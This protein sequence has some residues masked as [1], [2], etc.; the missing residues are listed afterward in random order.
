MDGGSGGRRARVTTI[1]PSLASTWKPAGCRTPRNCSIWASVQP[2]RGERQLARL[3]AQVLDRR[4]LVRPGRGRGLQH[5]LEVAVGG[6]AGVRAQ[7]LGLAQHDGAGVALDVGIGDPRIALLHQRL[8]RVAARPATSFFWCQAQRLRPTICATASAADADP[9]RPPGRAHRLAQ[10]VASGARAAGLA[11]RG[12]T[13]AGSRGCG[14]PAAG[15]AR[16]ASRSPARPATARRRR[17]RRARRSSGSSPAAGCGTRARARPPSRRTVATPSTCAQVSTVPPR[18]RGIGRGG[19]VE[20]AHR[21]LV[22][23]GHGHDP[24][25]E[26]AALLQRLELLLQPGAVDGGDPGLLAGRPPAARP[27][28]APTPRPRAGRPRSRRP[29]RRAA[30]TPAPWA[31]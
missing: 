26:D 14:R 31:G 15:A 30:A 29:A 17:R 5:R 24:V 3:E 9:H 16:P 7:R 8:D 2:V 22:R 1:R 18:R 21:R 25:D 4:P 10:P 11:A 6:L 23:P 28:G 27:R 19:D 20:V 12:R 13:G